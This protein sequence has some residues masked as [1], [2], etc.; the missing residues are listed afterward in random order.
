MH[1]AVSDALTLQPL[2]TL[3][4]TG[5]VAKIQSDRPY[6]FFRYVAFV[7]LADALLNEVTVN[8]HE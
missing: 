3:T 7:V 5:E 2:L 4:T 6:S 1:P 8:T